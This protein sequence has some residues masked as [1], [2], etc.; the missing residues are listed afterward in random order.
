MNVPVTQSPVDTDQQISRI[1]THPISPCTSPMQYRA[2][3]LIKG[4]YHPEEESFNKGELTTTDGKTFT[5][6]LLGRV[7]SLIKNHIDL[8]QEHLWVVYPRLQ[9][10]RKEEG[11]EPEEHI[12]FQVMGIWEPEQLYSDDDL[13]PE[14]QEAAIEEVKEGFFSIRG[15]VIFHN[16]EAQNII[17]KIRQAPKKKGDKPKFFKLKLKGVLEG[18]TLGHFWDIEAYFSEGEFV[19]D[20]ATNVGQ[21]PRRK[22]FFK[23]PGDNGKGKFNKPKRSEDGGA[24]VASDRHSPRPAFERPKPVKKPRLDA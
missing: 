1:K 6:F 8:T 14:A 7:V 19:V 9:Q 2:I 3:G 16:A 11:E 23:R 10:T 13:S 22:K 18:R 5:T 24:P 12:I 4:I 15:E 17:I 20:Q 21:I